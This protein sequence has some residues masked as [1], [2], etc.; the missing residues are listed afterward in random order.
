ML[1]PLIP[2]V[3]GSVAGNLKKEAGRRVSS[4]LWGCGCSIAFFAV[5]GTLV[6]VFAAI[7]IY[8]VVTTMPN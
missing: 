4:W 2:G 1:W 3:G 8:A 7:V 5:F 6:L